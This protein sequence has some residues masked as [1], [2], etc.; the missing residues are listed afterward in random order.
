MDFWFG[1]HCAPDVDP[2]AQG[3]IHAHPIAGLFFTGAGGGGS[4]RMLKSA[5]LL[6]VVEEASREVFG[7]GKRARLPGAA[8]L[9]AFFDR[10]N[11]PRSDVL[12]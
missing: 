6:R 12:Q 9:T 2:Y 8:R 1:G 10:I 4:A 7:D 3:V 5:R 11:V